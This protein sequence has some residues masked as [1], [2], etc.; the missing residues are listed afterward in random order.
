MTKTREAKFVECVQLLISCFG[1]MTPAQLA[2]AKKDWLEGKER[3]ERE[4]RNEVR[5]DKRRATTLG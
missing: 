3:R 1:V 5:R 2:E 4:R